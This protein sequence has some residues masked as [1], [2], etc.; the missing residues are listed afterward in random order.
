MG[1]GGGG[2]GGNEDDCG[3]RPCGGGGGG[4]GGGSAIVFNRFL[5]CGSTIYMASQTVVPGG[6]IPVTFKV[7]A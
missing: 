2:G 4:G 6:C 3:G 7:A 5:Q 1:G